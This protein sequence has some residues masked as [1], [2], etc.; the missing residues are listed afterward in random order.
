MIQKTKFWV[1]HRRAFG[2]YDWYEHIAAVFGDEV[3]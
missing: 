1:A 3:H 2:Q